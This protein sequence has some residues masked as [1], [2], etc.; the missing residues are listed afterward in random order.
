MMVSD[1]MTDILN[2]LKIGLSIAVILRALSQKF[3]RI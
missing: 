1:S 3:E 2:I